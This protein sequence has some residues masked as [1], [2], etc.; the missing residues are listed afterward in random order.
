MEMLQRAKFWRI[1][2]FVLVFAAGLLVL[3]NV[4]G[5]LTPFFL[6][7][8]LA[9]LFN[10]AVSAVNRRGFSRGIS[11][12][13]VYLILALVLGSLI[14]FGIPETFKELNRFAESLPRYAGEVQSVLDRLQAGYQ[15]AGLPPGVIKTID[16]NLAMGQDWLADKLQDLINSLISL[17]TLLPLV[18]LSPILSIY[19][20]YDWERLKEGLKRAVPSSW[21]GNA[22]HLGQEVSLVIRKFL[23]GNLTVAVIVGAL[24]G[25][26]M[27]LIHMDYALLIGVISGVF[28]L[29]PYFGPVIG[30]IPALALALL[31]S[32]SMALWTLAVIF[33]VQQ[34]E[35]NIIQPKIMGDSIGLHPLVIVFALLAGGD[36]FGFWG[37]LL[38]V[39]AAGVIRVV[40][41]YVYLKLV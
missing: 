24:V 39:P 37:M 12:A 23:R 10:P 40:F 14:L 5:I 18:I 7:F 21:R 26:G 32:K 25:L 16:S 22:I 38:A 20:L 1:T 13:L 3:W 27:K 11:I 31:K 33:V 36:L 8:F 15:Q 19:L 4:R 28:D 29:I 30:A 41:K 9:Y 2:L 34:V 17:V 6:A 35:S